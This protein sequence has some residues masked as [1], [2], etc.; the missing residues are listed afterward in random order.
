M[1]DHFFERQ[2]DFQQH[3]VRK[4]EQRYHIAATDH[5]DKRIARIARAIQS[6]RSLLR[7][8]TTPGVASRRE[9][10]RRDHEMADEAKRLGEF[11]RDVYGADTLTQEQMSESLKRIR[12]RM[13]RRNWKDVLAKTIP[14]PLGPRIL[15]I[16]V[17]EPIAV[18]DVAQLELA[19]YETVLLELTRRRMQ[20]ALDRINDSIATDVGTYRVENLLLG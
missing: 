20:D 17:P 13:L 10:L 6:E 16:G 8:D 11:T 2:K 12:D 9:I 3:L 4:L 5:L 14:R 7:K 15:H 1:T 19:E 18:V